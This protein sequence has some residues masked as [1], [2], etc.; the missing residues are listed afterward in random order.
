[1]KKIICIIYLL[2]TYFNP[3]FARHIRGGEMYYQFQGINN[4]NAIYTVTLK[5][6]IDCTQQQPGQLD[7]EVPF[8]IFTRTNNAQYGSPVNALLVSQEFIKYDPNSNPCIINP[9][10]DV[11]Y[12]LR[13]YQTQISLPV[14]NDGYTISYQ[15]CCRLNNIVN[16]VNSGGIGATYMCQIPGT[17]ILPDGYTNSSI[18]ITGNDA[19]AICANNYFTFDFSGKDPDPGDVVTYTLCEA[20]AGAGQGNG[21]SGSCYTCI[22]PNPAAP[23]PYT[24]ATYNTNF[25]AAFPL[26][27]KVNIDPN[28]G[29]I[30]GIAPPFTGTGQF[31]V[32]VCVSEFKRGKLI[33]VHRKDIHI[34]VSDCTP[35]RALLKPDYSYCEDLNVTFKNEQNNP[36]G[37]IFIWSFG[38]K[39]KTDTSIVA[40][41]SIQHQ[42]ADTGTYVIKLRAIL[43]GVCKDSTTTLA[44]VYPGFYPGFIIIG[45]CLFTPINFIDTTKAKFG[46]AAKWRWNFGDETTLA[47]TSHV[48]APSWLYS[49]VGVKNVELIVESSKGCIDTVTKPVEIKTRPNIKLAFKDTLICSIDTLQI[50]AAGLGVFSWLPNINIINANTATP[51]V[52]PKTTTNYTVTLNENGCINTDVVK[53]RVVD[54]VTLDA[55]PDTTICLTD[56]VT[57][58]PGGDGLK[59]SWSPAATLNN[60][61]IKNPVARPLQ[62][63]TYT[64]TASIGKC[65]ATDNVTITTIPYPG[66]NAGPDKIICYGDTAFINA[67][68]VASSFVWSPLY[69]L[70]SPQSLTTP[71]W[72]RRT[73]SYVLTAYDNKGCPKPGRDTVKI[74][75]R[76]PIV[77]FAG[78]DT[79]I[80]IG[81]P[82]QL[83]GSGAP[84]FQWLPAT[85]L[86][87]NNIQ[88]PIANI[89]ANATYIMKAYTQEGCF[90]YDTINIKVFETT[91][92]IFVPNAFTPGKSVNNLFRPIPVGI[93]QIKYFRVYNRWGQLVYDVTDIYKGWNGILNGKIQATG[94]YVWMVE[95]IDYT[96]KKII[97]KG[98]VVL[99][100]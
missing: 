50:Q 44:K 53:V 11:C 13:Y 97:K 55:G 94:T 77:A 87:R 91:P 76:P 61:N 24:S 95:G 65:N 75:V 8:T 81:Q 73:T 5:L 25:S 93:Q 26:A 6:Y 47:D 48:N 90:A 67:T 32:T 69:N 18:R 9:P 40:N 15:R 56:P 52:F 74:I 86:N 89:S 41:G 1:M 96:G 60:P 34:K 92:D 49:S 23:P 21:N 71:A 72:P 83:N 82:L 22:S 3:L 46:V 64:T 80:V 14:S 28:R 51:L 68:I 57:L 98:T 39:T 45:S 62:T 35:L 10:N 59:Y 54:Y 4:G 100:K 2:L 17:S 7:N 27:P 88:N 12:N 99:I 38:D 16:V 84:L 20:Y 85:G 58:Q 30:S 29:I 42:Y 36:P 31:V 63:T 66:S 43:A 33:N 78:N 19:V 37:T 70:G 79:A